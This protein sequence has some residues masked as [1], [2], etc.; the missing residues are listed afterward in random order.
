VLGY[1][2]M[3]SPPPTTDARDRRALRQLARGARG[4]VVTLSRAGSLLS[5][6]PRAVSATLSGLTRRGWLKRLRR[7]LY[8]VLPLEAE[9]RTSGVVEDPW[10]LAVELFSPCYIAGWSA[11]E[12]WGLTEQIFR[13]TFVATATRVRRSRQDVAGAQFHLAQVPRS[14]LGGVGTM[15]RGSERVP[16]SSPERTIADGL[17]DP[18]WVGG[19]RHLACILRAHRESK[20]WRT[21][22]LIAELEAIGTGAAYKR[23][24]FLVEALGLDAPAII[25]IAAVRKTTGIVKLDPAIR[26]RGRLLKCWGIWVN[27]ALGEE[28]RR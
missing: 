19:V 21:E 6:P 20:T 7:G 17:V 13:S 2:Q 8:L 25:D 28:A 11:A 18:S 26:S 23:I 1:T 5:T 14:R 24:G 27:A 3:A 10:L 12:H 16:L 15:W 4:G 9:A 22:K